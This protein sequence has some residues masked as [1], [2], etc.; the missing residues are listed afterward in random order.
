LCG[1]QHLPPLGKVVVCGAGLGRDAEET[2]AAVALARKPGIAVEVLEG[3]YAAW[4]SAH[5]LTTQARGLKP[6]ALNFISYAQLK[7][8]KAD[9]VV[10]VDLRHP[11]AA[12]PNTAAAAPAAQPLTDLAQAFPGFQVA[13]S[14][15]SAKTQ[16]KSAAAG[17]AP[18]P[19]LVLIDNGD[20]T[21]SEMARTLQGNG[22][23]RYA[24]LAGG[25]LILARQGQPGLQRLGA[26]THSTTAM[27]LPG[28]AK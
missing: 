10:L 26:G 11:P 25:E 12:K 23:K 7:A 8:A 20:G 18:P 14:A 3:G 24:I 4:E 5:G 9:D 27:P 13:P 19:L 22:I 2:A 21:A 17:S 6:E 1:Q 15:F 16:I 28:P